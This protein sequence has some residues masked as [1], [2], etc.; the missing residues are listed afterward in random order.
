M[1]GDMSTEQDP[2]A[3]A[4]SPAH[5][6]V[7]RRG[8]MLAGL[9]LLA[10]LI[11]APLA[12]ILV[13]KVSAS[14]AQDRLAS[15]QEALTSGDLGGAQDAVASAQRDVFVLGAAAGSGPMR[16]LGALPPTSDA[17]TDLDHMVVAIQHITD[18]SASAVDA[19]TAASGDEPGTPALF[20]DGRVA[21]DLLPQFSRTVDAVDA[22]LAAA[23]TALDQVRPEPDG[24]E[25]IANARD[26]ALDQLAP[27]QDT[28]DRVRALIPLLPGALG[29]T[30]PRR[31]LVT[32]LNEGELRASGG[33]PLAVAVIEFRDGA[34]SIPFKGAVAQIPWPGVGTRNGVL[35][36]KGAPASPWN[37]DGG[38]RVDRF[39]N[40]NF[41][42]DF[43]SAGYDMAGAWEAGNYGQV[44]GVVALDVTSLAAILRATGPIAE[45][46]YGELTADNIGQ[47]LLIDAYRLYADDQVARQT[48]N[49]IIVSAVFE[50]LT[51]AGTA[52]Q[53][54]TA[55]AD[56]APGRHVQ[57]WMR[58]PA[59][60]R[61]VH[62]LGLDGSLSSTAVDHAGLYA[63]NGNSSKAD[64]FQNRRLTVDATLAA[65]G[66][67]QV[68]Q[69][70]HVVQAVPN[71]LLGPDKTGYLSSWLDGSWFVLRPSGATD[72]RVTRPEGWTLGRWPAGGVWVDDGFG[73]Q[74]QRLEG[75][76]APTQGVE[77]TLRYRL[78]AGTFSGPGGSLRYQ[79]TV[80]P[81][82]IYGP[83]QAEV[84]ARGPDGESVTETQD[85]DRQVAFSI[86]VRQPVGSA[87]T[88]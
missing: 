13:V 27:L 41:H 73:Q 42:L 39:A 81:Q 20:A 25:S 70:W 38:D 4:P 60:A 88:S 69:T 32:M 30:T 21:V 11:L 5:R 83:A 33:A 76:I 46:P 71:E 66:S 15:A 29:D 26:D 63:Q 7:T 79:L 64:I 49:Q 72:T 43:R 10:S 51:Q 61:Q 62:E 82:A 57:M 3:A 80:E 75:A 74:V 47:K 36:W 87:T 35:R 8:L 23:V 54:A 1:T 19:Y 17:V 56:V 31:Y 22:D 28:V 59:L 55:L 9:V 50:R 44:D 78:P 84:T 85:L 16:L 86:D 58:D 53:V 45:S 65:D 67:A 37:W 40:A 12:S 48:A 2:S 68:T 34:F 24:L 14:A 52:L 6:R 77:L 18:A